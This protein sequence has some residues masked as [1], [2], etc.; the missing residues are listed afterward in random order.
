MKRRSQYYVTYIGA[1]IVDWELHCNSWRTP[2]GAS[3]PPQ[4]TDIGLLCLQLALSTAADQMHLDIKCAKSHAKEQCR[5]CNKQTNKQ[6]TAIDVT[7]V[8]N[9]TGLP[10]LRRSEHTSPEYSQKCLSF[11]F[12]CVIVCCAVQCCAV[13]CS[14][15]HIRLYRLFGWEGE[16]K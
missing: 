1:E 12:V 4:C 5:W 3:Q 15:V 7:D 14:A 9:A 2:T 16:H 11:F 13:L 8:F 6:N 10:A